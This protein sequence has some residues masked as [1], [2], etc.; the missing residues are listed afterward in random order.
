MKKV[1][2]IALVV[3]SVFSFFGCIDAEIILSGDTTPAST[4][5]PT[6][7]P[8]PPAPY[9]I[10]ISS[11][12]TDIGQIIYPSARDESFY[13]TTAPG[14]WIAKE[15]DVSV[16]SLLFPRYE[17]LG[18][19]EKEINFEAFEKNY[20]LKYGGSSVCY[21]RCI[22]ETYVDYYLGTGCRAYFKHG[23]KMPVALSFSSISDV[24]LLKT[25]DE[26]L[27]FIDRFVKQY[28][29]IDY[30]NYEL[31]IRSFWRSTDDKFFEEQSF[32]EPDEKIDYLSYTF[33]FREK[34][35]GV[36]T[37][38]YLTFD[39]NSINKSFSFESH[40]LDFDYK[41]LQKVTDVEIEYATEMVDKYV[42][43]IMRKDKSYK[44][45]TDAVF[46]SVRVLNGREYI[47]ITIGIPWIDYCDCEKR[48][49]FE[50]L[51][52]KEY[53]IDRERLCWYIALERAEK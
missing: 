10:D 44:R 48:E 15:G 40:I 20:V 12:P 23:T 7:I 49:E 36:Y 18:D 22:D 9:D 29:D 30:S 35:N 51:T 19:T 32:F 47:V 17:K 5:M 31:T 39:F 33:K 21:N 14:G 50:M 3:L 52:D 11:I 27:S 8:T 53:Y 16:N 25:K 26:Y 2:I 6:P 1:L 43:E 28:I 42:R 45:I 37:N 34:I 46:E 4:S 13:N 24:S 41:S 38:N